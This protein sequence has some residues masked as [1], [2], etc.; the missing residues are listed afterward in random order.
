MKYM[1]FKIT[2]LQTHIRYLHANEYMNIKG[3]YEIFFETNVNR[4]VRINDKWYFL[5]DYLLSVIN[6]DN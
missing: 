4:L 6:R 5:K 2:D 3:R 1:S